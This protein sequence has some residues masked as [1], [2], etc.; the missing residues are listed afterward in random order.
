[1]NPSLP[2][3][4][5]S[6]TF[7][8]PRGRV[9]RPLKAGASEVLMESVTLVPGVTYQVGVNLTPGRQAQQILDNYVEIALVGGTTVRLTDP[10]GDGRYTGQ[11]TYAVTAALAT[12]AAQ[13]LACASGT[14]LSSTT[15]HSN[16]RRC[17]S[18]WCGTRAR[19][20]R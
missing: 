11:F 6:L 3:D 18:Q 7:T 15:T 8:D 2:F 14:A 20:S 10:D 9:F 5:V 19:N 4:P 13:K 16:C 12:A 1:M 17:P